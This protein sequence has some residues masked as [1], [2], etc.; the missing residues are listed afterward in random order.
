VVVVVVVVVKGGQTGGRLVPKFVT[1]APKL[2]TETTRRR[3]R[4][5][6]Q[7]GILRTEQDLFHKTAAGA[8]RTLSAP[9]TPSS[10]QADFTAAGG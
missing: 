6:M 3:F 10:S 8:R 9:A 7:E 5:E 4:Q 1:R 2:Q